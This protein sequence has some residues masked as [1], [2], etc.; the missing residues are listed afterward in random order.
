MHVSN[1]TSRQYVMY[2]GMAGRRTSRAAPR[3][4]FAL[5]L[6][7][8]HA[9]SRPRIYIVNHGTSFGFTVLEGSAGATARV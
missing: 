7:S 4:Y 9:R 5:M 6:S 3:V 8:A 1:N 2:V